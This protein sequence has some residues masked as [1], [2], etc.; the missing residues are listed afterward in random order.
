MTN[1]E[2]FIFQPLKTNILEGPKESRSVYFSCLVWRKITVFLISRYPEFLGRWKP[3]KEGYE[4][5]YAEVSDITLPMTNFRSEDN[6]FWIAIVSELNFAQNATG[7]ATT[8]QQEM[9][10]F[11]IDSW[12]AAGLA[13]LCGVLCIAL[14]GVVFI[15]KRKTLTMSILPVSSSKDITFTRS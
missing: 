1:S 8:S 11:N 2:S 14:I 10:Y 12:G 5:P 7:E 15:T 4:L 3:L 13:V 9:E 6:E